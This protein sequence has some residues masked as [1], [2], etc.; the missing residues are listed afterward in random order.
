MRGPIGVM[1]ADFSLD[2]SSVPV[3]VSLRFLVM[4]GDAVSGGPVGSRVVV[5]CDGQGET[6]GTHSWCRNQRIRE[7]VD[8]SEP[9]A[10]R[11]AYENAS[12]SC[13]EATL[14]CR[15]DTSFD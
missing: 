11:T 2:C 4:R 1:D 3:G 9:L 15:A 13:R 12:P 5:L 10:D 7:W 6:H 14:A 8:S